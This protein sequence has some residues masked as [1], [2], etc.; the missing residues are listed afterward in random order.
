MLGLLDVGRW[1]FGRL[2]VGLLDVRRWTLT[3]DTGSWNWNHN[4][5]IKSNDYRSK[6]NI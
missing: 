4:V 1:T 2:D 5:L 6:S 3:L